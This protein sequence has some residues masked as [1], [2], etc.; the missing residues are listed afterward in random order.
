[1]KKTSTKSKRQQK[2]NLRFA[3]EGRVLVEEYVGK[4]VVA[5][6]EIDGQVVLRVLDRALVDALERLE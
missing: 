3:L 1:M 5:S 4:K 6:S 2:T